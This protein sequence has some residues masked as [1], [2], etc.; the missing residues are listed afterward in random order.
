MSRLKFA[1]AGG[2]RNPNAADWSRDGTLAF[3]AGNNIA[4]WRPFSGSSND[5]STST[6]AGS[7]R[8]QCDGINSL[9]TG[10]TDAV[11]VVKFVPMGRGPNER[12]LL[13]GSADKTIRLWPAP[14]DDKAIVLQAHSHA[15][16]CIATAD[17]FDGFVSGSAD[18]TVKVWRTK[19]QEHGI[20]FEAEQ[21]IQ[22]KPKYI[23][24]ALA[25]HSVDAGWV[26][27][28]AGTRSSIQVYVAQ[29]NAF[30]L[31]STL[32]GHEGWIRSLSF[33]RESSDAG[34][35]L[36]L[37]SASQDK[38]VRLWRLRKG[39]DLPAS[40]ASNGALGAL[41]GSLLLS[42][43]AHLVEFGQS[44]GTYS[45][46]FEALL[47][48]HED[49]VYTAVWQR[50]HN[51]LQLLTASADNSLAI[52]EAD[53]ECGVW[54]SVARLGEVSAQKGAT[55]A[56]GS[57]GGFW[58][59][60]WSPDGRSVA[61]LGRTG[62]W[63]LWTK[64]ED[65]R[66]WVQGVGVTGHAREVK[67]LAW[68][69]KGD[70]LLSTGLDQTTRLFAEW[71]RGEEGSTWH[72]FSRP[73]IHGY[74]LNCIAA[75][76]ETQFISGADEKLLRV[77][78]EPQT[79]ADMLEWLCHIERQSSVK[80][81]DAANIPVL[82][83]SNKAV[84]HSDED[85]AASNGDNDG[86]DAS[87]QHKTPSGGLEQDYPPTED[88]LARHMLWPEHEKLYGHGYEI[89]AV[90]ASHDGSL[91][92]TA[93]RASSLDHAVIRLYETNEWREVKPP[94]RAHSLTIH[95]LR[96]SPDDRYL[97][98]V[99]RD[100]QWTVFKRDAQQP[101]KYTQVSADPKGH[102]RMVLDCAWA[103]KG[104]EN[105]LPYIF[106]TAGRDKTVKIWDMENDTPRL[107][108]MLT[109]EAPITAVDFVDRLVDNRLLV[110]Y[111]TEAGSIEIVWFSHKDLA[112]ISHS[113]VSKHL[114]P[115]GSVTSIAWRPGVASRGTLE[116]AVASDD[117]SIR[118]LEL[119]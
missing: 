52:W 30:C 99:G 33:T 50:A 56:T 27:A 91:V 17:G 46:T 105:T 51:V 9:L 103:S 75:V 22:L 82:G 6:G 63:R 35:D 39:S 108:A 61:S 102:S 69:P 49:W 48:G 101:T 55:T 89:S 74:D 81:P 79:V 84:G 42:N 25:L 47:L 100:R 21:T 111:G 72:E 31:A 64:G 40:K 98:S 86:V 57:T 68:S 73:Q 78:N 76:S 2:N 5:E 34:S 117:H 92:A 54:L 107:K 67:S 58:I 112:V 80:M 95:R 88:Q 4:L 59:G 1:C 113:S 45:L 14:E 24:L 60:L 85:N 109:S 70:Y 8:R 16:N 66:L 90:A 87:V 97:L 65:E 12:L 44:D 32:T 71:R 28:I 13:S 115:S 53:K 106:A 10:H 104:T 116:L 37:A 43:K 20:S 29:E 94:L 11:T 23:P 41:T 62:S 38:Y 96:F 15:V 36:L 93:C 119:P 110:A 18:G 83:L 7:A 19:Q 26:L 118:I 77:F 3:G 114:L